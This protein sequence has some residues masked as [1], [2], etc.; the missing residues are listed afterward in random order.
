MLYSLADEK[1][2]F[3][4]I[5]TRMIEEELYE[6]TNKYGNKVMIDM[7]EHGDKTKP[8]AR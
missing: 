2:I 3:M 4:K 8:I 5:I 1:Y 6:A 7:R